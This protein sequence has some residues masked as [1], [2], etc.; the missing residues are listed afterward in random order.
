MNWPEIVLI[1]V[2]LRA[3]AFF[4]TAEA[5]THT[6]KNHALPSSRFLAGKHSVFGRKMTD[7]HDIWEYQHKNCRHINETSDKEV[8]PKGLTFSAL[9]HKLT[10][11]V[12][13]SNI[14]TKHII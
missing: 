4:Q 12:S 10:K 6:Y 1:F 5:H 13:W 7:F 11:R 8:M 9:E 2:I 3:S 14:V